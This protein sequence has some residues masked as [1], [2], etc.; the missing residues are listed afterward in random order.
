MNFEKTKK[1]CLRFLKQCAILNYDVYA[2][3]PDI[4][5]EI[6]FQVKLRFL[7]CAN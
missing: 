1:T 5:N 2:K 4:V 3:F 6:S 7:K